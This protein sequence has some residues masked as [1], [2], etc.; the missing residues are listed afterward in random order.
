MRAIVELMHL[1][2]RFGQSQPWL[3]GVALAEASHA[4]HL[5][6]DNAGAATLR[7]ELQRFDPAHPALDWLDRLERADTFGRRAGAPARSTNAES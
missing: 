5:L 6:G 4:L 1:P 7:D 3:T 2:A